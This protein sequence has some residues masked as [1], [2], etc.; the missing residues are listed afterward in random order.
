MVCEIDIKVLDWFW[1][2]KVRC[3]FL[4]DYCVSNSHPKAKGK[5]SNDILFMQRENDLPE[6]NFY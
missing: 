1:F 4:C 2:L 5:D 6:T 3:R